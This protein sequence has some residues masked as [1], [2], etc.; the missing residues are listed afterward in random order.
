[1]PATSEDKREK[2]VCDLPFRTTPETP[3]NFDA[4]PVGP[5]AKIGQFKDTPRQAA[6]ALPTLLPLFV[7]GGSYYL[8][9]ASNVRKDYLSVRV[10]FVLTPFLP[11]LSEGLSK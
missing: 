7:N 1:M 5:N 2:T 11:L 6:A 3:G 10:D 9:F 4:P 8:S